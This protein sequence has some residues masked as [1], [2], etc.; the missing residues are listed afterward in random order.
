[1]SVP[2]PGWYPDPDGARVVRWW[3]GGQWTPQERPV[4]SLNDLQAAVEAGVPLPTGA[5]LAYRLTR[6]SY[7]RPLS[8]GIDNALGEELAQI[9]PADPTTRRGSVLTVD[10]RAQ[11]TFVSDPNGMVVRGPGGFVGRIARQPFATGMRLSAGDQRVGTLRQRTVHAA[12]EIRGGEGEAQA[13]IERSRLGFTS[14]RLSVLT[15]LADPVRIPPPLL[16]AV[17]PAF[18]VLRR[19]ERRRGPR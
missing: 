12:V 10:G 14:A 11:L 19:E 7:R 2:S 8:Y 16:L 4:P 18:D 3:D 6:F 13:G 17:V 9:E 15:M 5:T 1:M